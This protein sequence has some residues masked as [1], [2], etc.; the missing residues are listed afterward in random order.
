[1]KHRKASFVVKHLVFG[2]GQRGIAIATDAPAAVGMTGTIFAAVWVWLTDK[3]FDEDAIHE[4]QGREEE[5]WLSCDKT[6]ILT[7]LEF[8][9]EIK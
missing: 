7:I 8:L 5:L 9:N 2:L 6:S 4:E 1:M 3:R